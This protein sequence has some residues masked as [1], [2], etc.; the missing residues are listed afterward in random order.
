MQGHARP[1]RGCGGWLLLCWLVLATTAYAEV[2]LSS[3]AWTEEERAYLEAHVL[4][5]AAVIGWQPFS[6]LGPEGQ[7]I[8]IS[9]DFWALVRDKLQLQETVSAPMRFADFLQAMQQGT[10]DLHASTARISERDGDALFSDYY[11]QYPIA[12]AMRRDGGLLAETGTLEGRIVAVGENH[13]AYHL[14][15]AGYPGI[16]FLRVADTHAAIA[17]VANGQAFAAAD[18]LPVIQHHIAE[19]EGSGIHLGGVTDVMFRLR[20]MVHPEHAPLVPLINRAIAAITPE[21]RLDLHRK[22]MLR[23]VITTQALDYRLLWTLVATALVVIGVILFWNHLLFRQI[24]RRRRV[25]QQLQ[26]TGERLR[27]ILASMDDL[28]FVLDTQQHF[29]DAYYPDVKRL[30]LPPE[31]FLGKTCQ[32]VLPPE[33]FM[34]ADQAIRASRVLGAQTFEYKSLKVDGERWSNASVSARYDGSGQFVGTTV[35]VRD[36][37]ALKQ[38]GV[39]LQRAKD[40]A[41]AAN[42]AKSAFLANMSHELRTPLHVVLGYTQILQ[43]D[44]HLAPDQQESLALI[45]RS[46][47]YLLT[48]INDVL[49]LAKIEAGHLDLVPGPCPLPGFFTELS[50]SFRL[51]AAE[52]GIALRCDEHA[53]P[54]VVELDIKR[55]RQICMNLLGNAIKFTERGEVCLSAAY[56]PWS[57]LTEQA[58]GAPQTWSATP[59]SGERDGIL[60]IQVRDTGIGIAPGLQAA[61]FEPFRQT[62][63]TRYQQQGT[64]LGL[65]ISRSLVEQM[66][67][68]ITLDSAEGQGSCFTL[69]IPVCEL[70]ATTPDTAPPLIRM[71]QHSTVSGSKA[72]GYRRLD[73]QNKPFHL[74]VVDDEVANR[75]LMRKLLGLMGFKVDEAASGDEALAMLAG[76]RYDLILMDLVMPGQDGL[77][78]TRAILAQT[79]TATQKIVAL[80]ARVFAEDRAQC[81]EAGCCGYLSKPMQQDALQAM[82]AAQLALRW[83]P[84]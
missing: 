10:V 24:K 32:E 54:A 74:L 31:E 30:L 59:T 49:D 72:L 45:K 4:R 70:P 65:A 18:I 1:I 23:D 17:A 20:I 78:T 51:R 64:G 41:E 69:R 57:A 60:S 52:K 25:E 37:T 12:V 80:T 3:I 76:Q 43:R 29:I 42:Q 50:H 84:H 61:I 39:D 8:G 38:A 83:D 13:S 36:I 15:K 77:A 9:E 46:G 66:G 47:D 44:V 21:E 11:E 79:A 67:G 7:I 35:V 81:L 34:L 58:A 53:L 68:S 56:E 48:L 40:A 55:L 63:E 62:G 82:L 28:V 22:W 5:R 26:D 14:L 6:F 2:P 19:W 33:I 16:D 71:L 75:K 27:S 73:G